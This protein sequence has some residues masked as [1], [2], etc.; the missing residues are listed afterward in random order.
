VCLLTHLVLDPDDP[1]CSEPAKPIGPFY[2]ERTTGRLAAERGI[3]MDGLGR[4][5]EGAA[6]THV[7]PIL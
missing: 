7:R 4:A 6:G 1:A 2:D 3:D 5:L